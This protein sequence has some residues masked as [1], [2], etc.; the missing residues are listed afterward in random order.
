MRLQ[1]TFDMTSKLLENGPA[2]SIEPSVDE[3]EDSYS[4]ALAETVTKPCKADP[5][6]CPNEDTRSCWTGHVG[7]LAWFEYHRVPESLG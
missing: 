4:N 5:L 7:I 6:P 3:Q 1:S 2:A